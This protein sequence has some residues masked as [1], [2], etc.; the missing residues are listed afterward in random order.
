MV[1]VV[2]QPDKAKGRGRKVQS[3]PVKARALELEIPI[4]Q[5]TSL[6]A[7]EVVNHLSARKPDLIVVAAY[8]KIL[9]PSILD[10]PQLGS[11]NVHA[12]LLPRWRGAA[13]VQA[14]ILHGDTTTGVTIMKM[15]PG[16]DTGDIL[17]QR[18]TP[19][20]PLETGGELSDRLS[21]LGAQLLGETIPSY[22]SGGLQPVPQDDSLATHAPMLKKADGW[23]DYRRPAEE[24]ARQVRAYDPWPGSFIEWSGGRLLVLRARVVASIQQAPGRLMSVERSPALGTALGCLLLEQVK[25]AG[26]RQ[27]TGEAFLMG[28]PQFE[29][30]QLS[31]PDP[32]RDASPTASH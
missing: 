6:K 29:G 21:V 16:L 25:P 7:E 4:F 27:M 5:P 26:K 8:G 13:P 23:L 14:A 11:I 31:S 15:D 30:E 9:P 20:Q 22:A 24:L 17:A 3:P 32:D 19:I 10:L 28:T 1:E 12:S 18:S 2:T